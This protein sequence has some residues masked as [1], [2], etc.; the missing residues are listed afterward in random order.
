[1]NKSKGFY[2]TRSKTTRVLGN[3][4]YTETESFSAG[5]LPTKKNVIEVM[6][7]LLRLD[8][9]G[10]SQLTVEKAS[11]IVACTL[12]EHWQ[13]CNIYTVTEKYVKRKVLDLYKEFKD[14]IKK[15]SINFYQKPE[16][17]KEFDNFNE[18]TKTL[19]DIFCEDQQ[20]RTS[21]EKLFHIKMTP[22]E[23]SFLEDMRTSRKQYCEP[24]VDRRWQNTMEKK[25]MQ[26]KSLE[27][28][29]Q[30]QIETQ[31]VVLDVDMQTESETN[32]ENTDSEEDTTFVRNSSLL[33]G[34]KRPFID[35]STS[36]SNDP[37][38]IGYQHLRESA[39]VIK[40]EFY[41]TVDILI[42]KY[43]CSKTQ[44]IVAVIETGKLMF[45]RSNWKFHIENQK[46]I[47]LDTAP[48]KKVLEELKVLFK[49]CR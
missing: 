29:R 36:S 32:T 31:I 42:S 23:W 40:P 47:D 14:K 22:M 9:A 35:T 5:V 34:T 30:R 11:H 8:R 18:K 21:L 13:Y 6:L 16:K 25:I 27:D 15:S 46:L 4:T 17:I 28:Q 2:V 3:V 7:Y 19:F 10:R 24:A 39:H 43:H 20:R 33:R 26:E 37:L 41:K 48:D 45:G 38:P 1:M 44:A 49:H 12:L